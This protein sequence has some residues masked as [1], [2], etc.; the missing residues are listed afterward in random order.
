MTP[1][2]MFPSSLYRVAFCKGTR[3]W[4]RRSLWEET[5]VM[6]WR[7]G[8]ENI[9][10]IPCPFSLDTGVSPSFLSSLFTWDW[11][12]SWPPSET[13]WKGHKERT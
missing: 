13:H 1:K 2:F 4:V 6:V 3:A 7:W 12:D 8:G 5:E 9:L 11:L 10:V